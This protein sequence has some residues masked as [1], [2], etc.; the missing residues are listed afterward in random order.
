M[1]AQSETFNNRDSF[2]HITKSKLFKRALIESERQQKL[3]KEK[4]LK[5]IEMEKMKVFKNKQTVLK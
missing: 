3:E 4:Y 2:A 1:N 5:R